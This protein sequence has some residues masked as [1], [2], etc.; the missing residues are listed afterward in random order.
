MSET[1]A[2]AT[3]MPL[4]PDIKPFAQTLL[5]HHVDRC[6][7]GTNWPHPGT[8]SNMP[9]DIDLLDLLETWIPNEEARQKLF[10]T[11][12]ERLYGFKPYQC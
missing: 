12:A 6:V 9:N 8:H 11:N 3:G 1:P 2:Q 5:K 4:Y 10:V 7:W